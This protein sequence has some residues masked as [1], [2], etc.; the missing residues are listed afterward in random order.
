M[1]GDATIW[2]DVDCQGMTLR[3]LINFALS[4]GEWGDVHIC[5]G[6]WLDHIYNLE[7]KKDRI[8]NDDIP[9]YIKDCRIRECE[10]NGGWGAMSYYCYMEGEKDA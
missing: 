4:R 10:A 8:V 3:E 9:E 6:G 7:Y 5:E 2:Y 1:L